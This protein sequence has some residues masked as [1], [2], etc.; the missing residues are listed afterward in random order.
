[1]ID[2][3]MKRR[4]EDERIDISLTPNGM[5]YKQIGMELG[6]SPQRVQQIEHSGLMKINAYLAKHPEERDNLLDLL[7][8]SKD[9]QEMGAV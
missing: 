5:T 3:T 2:L 1:M 6:I 9:N 8:Q 4:G 7:Q